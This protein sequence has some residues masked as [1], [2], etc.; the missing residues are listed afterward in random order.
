LEKKMEGGKI[1]APRPT[2]SDIRARTLMQLANLDA[3]YTRLLNPHVYKVS[4]SE[5]LSSLKVAMIKEMLAN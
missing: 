1:I 5:K 4:I 3:T 2:L